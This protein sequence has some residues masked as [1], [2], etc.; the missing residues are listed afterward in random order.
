MDKLNVGAWEGRAECH[1]GVLSE[2]QAAQVHAT[3]GVP[4][5]AAP[6]EGEAMAPLWHWCAFNPTVPQEELAR[7]GHPAPGGFLPPLRL[8]RRMWASGS[9]TF[10]APLRVGE[11]LTRHSFIS[12]VAEKEG[13]TGP[14]V[15][16]SV[17]HRIHGERGL[18]IEERQHIVYL[19]IPDRF[20]PPATRPLPRTPALHERIALSEAL[21][22]R[23]SALTFNAHRIHYDLPYAQGV[24]H[25]PGLVVHA[26]L[27]ASWL[28]RGGERPQ[29]PPAAPFRFF[30][31]CI[32][33]FLSPG[34]SRSLEIMGDEDESGALNLC[35][36]QQG[37]QGMQA[38]AIWEENGMNR[39]LKRNAR[40]RGIG[41][42]WRCRWRG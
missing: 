4:G 2:A 33:F 26:P 23:Y 17:D 34:E 36:G 38:T 31:P 20:R 12:R 32:R 27:Q 42:L 6:R 35:S 21:L 7:D 39:M 22:F 8:Q 24:E 18:A 28:I 25:Y 30:A 29:G 1:H 41:I 13:K 11:R 37:H 14:M 40:G 19:D 3:L 9:L 16:V 10:G 15:M 5:T